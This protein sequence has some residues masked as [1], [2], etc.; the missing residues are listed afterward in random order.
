[1]S[2]TR[3]VV[4]SRR[5]KTLAL[6][7]VATVFTAGCD[8]SAVHFG[9]SNT[10][11][12]P[13]EPALT[14]SSV[15]RLRV[16]WSVPCACR[17][18]ALV[19]GS[20]VYV[21]DGFSGDP[22]FSLTLRAFDATTGAARWST[23]LRADG[24]GTVADA[25]A[26]G[27]VY[28]LERSATVSDRIVALDATTG[29]VRWRLV[30]PAPGPRGGSV[31]VGQVIVDG[32]L[33]FVAA[34]GGGG[35]EVFALD[36]DGH[37]AWSAVPGGSFSLLAADSA[38]HTV[39]VPSRIR[40]NGLSIHLLT[41]YAEADGTVRSAVVAELP[42]P[43][44]YGEVESLGFSNGLVFGTQGNEHGQGG[45]GAFALHP[46]TGARAWSGDLSVAVLTPNAIVDTNFR[47]LLPTIA[48]DPSTGAVLWQSDTRTATDVVGAGNLIYGTIGNADGTV[49]A[50][51]R[52][53]S[54]GT[55]VATLPL[56]QD[57]LSRLTPSGGH[58]YNVTGTH[59]DA[60]APP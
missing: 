17:E 13:V 44:P 49:V 48:R 42:S 57:T 22:P 1:M 25:V 38:G 26:N 51:A 45:V 37:V 7:I 5:V 50:V 56:R 52:R 58:L 10:N 31:A 60:L 30:P 27:L 46:D 6:V 40:V 54:D 14:E 35:S 8:W 36:G 9:P 28:V 19:A 2:T 39:Y 47:S 23:P 11:F 43:E 33:A 15:P 59:L 21:I 18:R 32:P 29:V 34:T 20:L 4:R 53:L 41:G 16:A 24:F 55:V 12:N 3:P